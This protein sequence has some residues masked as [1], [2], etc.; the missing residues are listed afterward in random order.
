MTVA[1]GKGG[2]NSE[3]NV[4]P[5]IDVLL[6]LLIIF[7]VVQQQ[8]QRGVSVQLPPTTGQEVPGLKPDQIVLQVEPGPRYLLNSQPV[9]A[10]SLAATLQGV[11]APRPRK[12]VFVQGAEGTSYGDVIRAVDAS[13]AAG[14]QVVGLVPRAERWQE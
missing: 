13:R 12:V 14:V 4:T 2:P 10:A 7:M 1:R 9:A 5:M 11:F 3:I 6:V 8:L